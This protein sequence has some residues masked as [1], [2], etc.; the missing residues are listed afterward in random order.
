M[1]NPLLAWAEFA[2][3]SARMMTTSAQ[4]IGQRTSRMMLAGTSPGAA[5]RKELALMNS[6]K[7]AAAAE[8]AQA[9]A[10]GMFVLSQ[11][12]AA[13]MF[14][15]IFAAAPLMMSLA[16]SSTPQQ[17]A[18]RQVKLVSVGLSNTKEATS[19]IT[20]AL[21]RIAHKGL[22]PIHSKATANRK[23]LSRR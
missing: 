11:Q 7:S 14:R 20:S 15:Q 10:Q 9:M 21:P 3:A 5:D 16:A 12:L 13:M 17:S 4:V 22:R 18:A 1:T 23:R 6:E 8:S 19:R 2:M